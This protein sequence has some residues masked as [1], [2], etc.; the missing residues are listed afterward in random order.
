MLINL[1]HAMANAVKSGATEENATRKVIARL[2]PRW[3]AWLLNKVFKKPLEMTWEGGYLE[4]GRL[5]Y[6]GVWAATFADGTEW[7]QE[8]TKD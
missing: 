7:K 5:K 1:K 2:Y 8:L 3:V 6:R 4:D